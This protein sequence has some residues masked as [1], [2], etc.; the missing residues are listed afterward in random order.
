VLSSCIPKSQ[1]S[2]SSRRFTPP[3]HYIT[4][5]NPNSGNLLQITVN[6]GWAKSG[7]PDQD[8]SY[9]MHMKNGKSRQGELSAVC[10]DRQILLLLTESDKFNVAGTIWKDPNHPSTFA[11]SEGSASLD[12]ENRYVGK[13]Y[14]IPNSR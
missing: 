9:I 12:N 13:W 11:I 4:V 10:G 6:K 2:K 7:P 3:S 1:Y 5:K 8:G 14:Y